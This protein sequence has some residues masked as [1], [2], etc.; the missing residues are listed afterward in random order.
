MAF[1]ATAALQAFSVISG[2]RA[3]RQQAIAQGKAMQAQARSAIK[4]M[5]YA[6]QNYE[7]ERKDAFDTAVDN[8]SRIT[9]ATRGLTSGVDA[10]RYEE[11]DGGNTGRLLSRSTH[12]EALQAITN[13]KDQYDR[14]SNEIDLNKETKLLQT[15]EFTE[16][17]HPPQIPS[18]TKGLLLP[19]ATTALG[20]YAQ[21]N[22]KNAFQMIN[23]Y[24]KDLTGTTEGYKTATPWTAPN[25]FLNSTKYTLSTT[26]PYGQ[27][28]A[29]DYRS[30]AEFNRASK[31]MFGKKGV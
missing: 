11:M 16:N 20:V 26:T 24:A 29:K 6:F 19:L 12:R 30:N 25:T 9:E 7:G 14:R 17:L 23:G 15:K 13:E 31:I 27:Y 1:W 28:L 21:E 22:D 2:Y 5:N 18:L 3:Q 8:L 10:A 4:S